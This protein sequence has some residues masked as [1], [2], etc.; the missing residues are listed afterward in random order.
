MC[1]SDCPERE[2]AQRRKL[3]E[4]IPELCE[5]RYLTNEI[6][7]ADTETIFDHN[8]AQAI[9]LLME[10]KPEDAK[11]IAL[12][13]LQMAAKRV[14]NDNTIMYIKS[15]LI[16][17]IGISVPISILGGLSYGLY[18][19]MLLWRYAIAA[20]FGVYRGGILDHHAS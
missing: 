17:A 19:R 1:F 15:S 10:N 2:A 18:P 4:I 9:M 20:A 16:A 11:R 14:T 6:R 5:L 7:K 8:I 3:T 12:E 13:A